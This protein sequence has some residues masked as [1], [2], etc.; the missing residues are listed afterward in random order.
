MS[1]IVISTGDR[2]RGTIAWRPAPTGVGSGDYQ[3]TDS[4]LAGCDGRGVRR[5]NRYRPPLGRHQ[6]C[7]RCDCRRDERRRCCRD[8]ASLDRAWRRDLASTARPL[9][10]RAARL[11]RV[12]AQPA[13]VGF[14]NRPRRICRQFALARECRSAPFGAQVRLWSDV[15]A[16]K[17]ERS[18]AL[19]GQRFGTIN[20]SAT[21][22]D[23]SNG[24]SRAVSAE[25]LCSACKSV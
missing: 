20:L 18:R 19:T 13:R 9:R 23:P 21:R 24:R 11:A 17:I 8:R 2:A 6:R 10:P 3:T 5:R 1:A 12:R 15:Q 7:C 14:V 16:H 25:R 22:P 4:A